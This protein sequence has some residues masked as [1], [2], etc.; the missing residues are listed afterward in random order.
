MRCLKSLSNLF[1]LVLGAVLVCGFLLLPPSSAH[2]NSGM[3]EGAHA[4][5]HTGADSEMALNHAQ[6][7]A[8]AQPAPDDTPDSFEGDACCGGICMT[9]ALCASQHAEV[10]AV[11]SACFALSYRSM[12]S[13]DATSQLRPPRA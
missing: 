3:H 5:H 8:V 9:A 2:A 1:R 10:T 12:A 4:T 13:A 11:Q 7:A 6:Q